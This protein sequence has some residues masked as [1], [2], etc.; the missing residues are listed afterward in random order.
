[1]DQGAGIATSAAATASRELRIVISGLL[2]V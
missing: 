2:N 1:M